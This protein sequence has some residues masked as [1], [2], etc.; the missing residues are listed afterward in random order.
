MKLYLDTSDSEKMTIRLDE[1]EYSADARKEKSQLL[2]PFLTETLKN[3][4]KQLSD[5][6]EIEVH[7]GPGSFTGLR[8]GLSVANAL[9]YAYKVPVNGKKVWKGEKVHLNYEK[10]ES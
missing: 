2:L 1:Q 5:I 4:G 3:N 8:V 7:T 9:S 10:A 6:T